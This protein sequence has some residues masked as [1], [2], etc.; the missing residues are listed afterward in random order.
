MIS[1]VDNQA[2][3]VNR[4]VTDLIKLA[5][6]T[7]DS[8]QLEVGTH[9]VS[10]LTE[11]AI[12]M[13]P[14]LFTDKVDLNTKFEPNLEVSGDRGRLTQVL[15]NLLTNAVRYGNGQIRLDAH[16]NGGHVVL[17]VHDNGPGVPKRYEET[18][19]ERFERGAHRLDASV[20]GSG[21]G[22]PIARSLVESHGGTIGYQRSA[23]LGGACFTVSVPRGTPHRTSPTLQT[24]TTG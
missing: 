3:H 16:T 13:V 11:D 24:T 4:I 8:T 20:P 6:D 23:Q 14:E 17:E 21:I 12:A 2:Q 1:I 10:T 9:L 18:I 7:L 15:V 22:L 5:R 19:W